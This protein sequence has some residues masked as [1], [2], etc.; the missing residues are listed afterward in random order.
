MIYVIWY[1]DSAN[2]CHCLCNECCVVIW[3][4]ISHRI[5]FR[6]LHYLRLVHPKQSG[7]SSI[8]SCTSLFKRFCFPISPFPMNQPC[9]SQKVNFC[10]ISSLIEQVH[11]GNCLDTWTQIVN[12]QVDRFTNEGLLVPA[13]KV[14]YSIFQPNE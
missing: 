13:I 8:S 11:H 14:V 4:G 3:Y 5:F 6:I 7:L 12:C 1:P 2:K 9:S 10:I